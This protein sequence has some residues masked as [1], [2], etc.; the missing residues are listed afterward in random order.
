MPELLNAGEPEAVLP[1]NMEK[2]SQLASVAKRVKVTLRMQRRGS[3]KAANAALHQQHRHLMLVGTG[4]GQ[5]V[6]TQLM[7][8]E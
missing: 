4:D 5:M 3:A 8:S 2:K 7:L 6:H 1:W